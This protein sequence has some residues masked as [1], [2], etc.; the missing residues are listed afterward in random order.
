MIKN[1]KNSQW[2]RANFKKIQEKWKN[3]L[4]LNNNNK[5]KKFYCL[6]MFPY[7]SGRIHMGHVRNYTMRCEVTGYKSLKVLMYYK[8]Y[9]LG[10]FWFYENASEK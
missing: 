10:R 9:G 2:K 5:N 6:E 3:K 7:P 8:Y 1:Q 4:D